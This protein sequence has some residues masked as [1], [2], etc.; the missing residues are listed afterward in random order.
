M[1]MAELLSLKSVLALSCSCMGT[2]LREISPP[3]SLRTSLE[4]SCC[5]SLFGVP[6]LKKRLIY[7]DSGIK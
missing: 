6:I 4:R 1:N 2:L 5:Q 7:I 3:F